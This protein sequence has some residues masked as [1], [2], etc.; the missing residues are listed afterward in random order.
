MTDVL[1]QS[2]PKP[3]PQSAPQPA[4]T[5]ERQVDG[6]GLRRMTMVVVLFGFLYGLYLLT[7]SGAFTTDDERVIFDTIESLA[8]RGNMLL[9]QT[10]YLTPLRTSSVEP[11]QPILAVPLYWIANQFDSVGNVHGVFLFNPL[12]TAL[13]AVALYWFALDL[14]YGDRE[15]LLAGL[16]FGAATIAW[17]YTK[18]LFRE[19]LAGLSLT[20]T[21]FFLHRWREGFLRHGGKSTHTWLGLAVLAFL[22]LAFTKEAAMSAAPVLAVY[23]FPPIK[24]L[25]THR[26]VLLVLGVSL[27]GAAFLMLGGVLILHSVEAVTQRYDVLERVLKLVNRPRDPVPGIVGLLFSPGKSVFV[28]SPVALLSIGA[29]LSGKPGGRREQ[30]MAVGMLF[31]FVVIYPVSRGP[32]WHGGASWGPRYLV[33]LSSVLVLGGLPL[34]KWALDSA[35]LWPKVGLG[36]LVVLSVAVQMPGLLINIQ[37]YYRSL[38]PLGSGAQWTIAIWKPGYSQLPGHLRLLDDRVLDLAWTRLDTDRL[39]LAVLGMGV[40]ALGAMLV[41]VASI[42]GTRRAAKIYVGS[43]AVLIVMLT[44]FGLRR[45]YHDPFFKGD[46]PYLHQMLARVTDVAGPDDTIVLSNPAYADFFANYYK[47]DTQ[48]YTM[49]RSP[50]ERHSE[51]EVPQVVSDDVDELV[52]DGAVRLFKYAGWT[53]LDGSIWL[54]VDGGIYTPWYP[55]PPE[56]WAAERY[57]P[58]YAEEFAPTARLVQYLNFRAPNPATQHE[59]DHGGQLGEGIVLAGYDLS[60]FNRPDIFTFQP[61]DQVGVSLVWQAESAQDEDYIVAVF[62]IDPDGQIVSQQDHMP[63]GTFRPTS[64]WQSGETL[65]DNYGFIL[66]D[67]AQPGRYEIWTTMYSWPSLERLPATSS[68]GEDLGDLLVVTEFEVVAPSRPLD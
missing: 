40:V 24:T 20:A 66:P 26:R 59:H 15:A 22:I 37:E 19:P 35:K 8:E 3:L 64:G 57:Y 9:N 44:G 16:L 48:W 58:V 6:V 61:G 12:V 45:A 41:R 67:D 36:V 39:A 28:Y 51:E 42:P 54:V 11:A 49:P 14:G 32:L 52:G 5:P 47:G 2:P 62:L 63:V 13:T 4:S 56:W 7:Y 34:V 68:S 17:P 43:V 10:T 18:T 55:R 46:L 29:L 50:G 60:G 53:T 31:T 21:L 30:W 23:A 65:R 38:Q 1:V 33:P 25:R 27:L